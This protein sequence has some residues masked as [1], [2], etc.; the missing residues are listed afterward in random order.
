[1]VSSSTNKTENNEKNRWPIFESFKKC[2]EYKFGNY[3]RKLVAYKG[4]LCKSSKK[5]I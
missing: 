3:F 5:K 4:F 1:M 2:R